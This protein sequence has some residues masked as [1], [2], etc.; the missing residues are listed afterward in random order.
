[1]K[2]A[3]LTLTLPLL[4]SPPAGA[5]GP[6]HLPH[7]AGRFEVAVVKDLAYYEGKDADP[8]KHKLDLYYP[9][10][11]AGYPVLFF[12]HG[13]SWRSGDKRIYAPLGEVFAR[14]GVGAVIVNYR[15][16]PKVKHPAHAEDVARAFAWTVRNV[17]R[18]GGR[19]EQIFVC[20][21]SAGGH[22]VSLLATDESYLKAHKLGLGAIKGVLALSG[23]YLI[24]PGPTRAAFGTAPQVCR[25]ASP[26]SHVGEKR[27]PF[28]LVYADRDYPTLGWMAERMAHALRKHKC[29]AQTMEVKGR[30]HVSLIVGVAKDDSTAGAILRFIAAHTGP[31]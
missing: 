12:V 26:L 23:V 14:H 29:E 31:K 16:S 13:G 9:R 20:G 25:N 21:H 7:A 30:T 24:F 1:M 28:L 27:P 4:L 10:D 17:A 19:A 22:L 11:R 15:L 2:R 18:Y 3:L 8:V 6:A 5:A